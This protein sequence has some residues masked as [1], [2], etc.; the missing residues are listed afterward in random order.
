MTTTTEPGIGVRPEA[1]RAVLKSQYHAALEMLAQA[2]ELCP[3]H[4]WTSDAYPNRFWRL[5]Y[6]AVFYAD[7]YLRPDEASFRAWENHRKDYQFLGPTPFPP[8]LSPRIGEPYSKAQVTDY[9]RTCDSMVDAAVDQLDLNSPNS[10][11]PWYKMS[12]LEHQ[13][14]NIRHI[15]H[16]AAQLADRVRTTEGAGVRWVAGKPAS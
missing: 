7:M 10:G 8:H 11:F 1:L 16:H 12:K 2:I 4:L 6:H 9:L 15:Q 3:D 5:A 13:L 14:V